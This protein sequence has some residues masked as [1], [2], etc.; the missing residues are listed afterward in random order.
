[1]AEI[2]PN[3]IKLFDHKI[4]LIISPDKLSAKM[5]ISKFKWPTI[6]ATQLMT[7]L[8]LKK[9]KQGIIK[10][11]IKEAITNR[12]KEYVI[13]Q[14]TPPVEGT[15][16]SF[17]VLFKSPDK[18]L[19]PKVSDQGIVN[20]RE[21]EYIVSIKKD[22]PLVQLVPAIEGTAGCDI[23]GENIPPQKIQ[24]PNIQL[25]ENVYLNESSQMIC[26]IVSGIPGI[27]NNQAF[28]KDNVKIDQDI[29]YSIG[30]INIPCNL[31]IN[32]SVNE[33][34]KIAATGNIHIT[35]EVNNAFIDCGRNLTIGKG[36][37]NKNS[38]KVTVEGH[39]HCKYLH[40]AN[41]IVQGNLFVDREIL[42]STVTCHK[43]INVTKEEG[44]IIGGTIT[45]EYNIF[46]NEIGSKLETASTKITLWNIEESLRK[47]AEIDRE[48]NDTTEM[49]AQ[50]LREL[51]GVQ[52]YL[53]SDSISAEEFKE[54]ESIFETYLKNA[55]SLKARKEKLLLYRNEIKKFITEKNT[56][57]IQIKKVIHPG[58]KIRI[59]DDMLITKF[60]EKRIAFYYNAKKSKIA[61]KLL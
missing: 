15:N 27:A 2:S 31:T 7:Y 55:N 35:G 32:G 34:F 11:N 8:D 57:E 36:I 37:N 1:M 50:T 26:A 4:R 39:L 46:A 19:K 16:G 49:L 54:F 21:I 40:H 42:F 60:E 53:E 6:K 33:G 29:D 58:V 20:L 59:K 17:S 44:L 61:S 24:H 10:D 25:G 38:G 28:V 47:L 5:T 23:Y 30:N 43:D 9:I 18:I 51:K 22:E 56:G 3:L 41:V 13:A 12:E 52:D 45:A 48:T 14:G